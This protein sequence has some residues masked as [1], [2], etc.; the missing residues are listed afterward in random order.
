[1]L[2]LARNLPS[3]SSVSWSIVIHNNTLACTAPSVKQFLG[4]CISKCIFCSWTQA[5][6]QWCV[7]FLIK[8]NIVVVPHPPKSH[9]LASCHF[10]LFLKMNIKLKGQQLDNIWGSFSGISQCAGQHPLHVLLEMLP[11]VGKTMNPYIDFMSSSFYYQ[12]RCFCITPC[13]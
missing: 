11:A 10:F 3:Q 1:M 7:Q 6:P 2:V 9:D 13:I 8:N 12:C 4:Q 5:G